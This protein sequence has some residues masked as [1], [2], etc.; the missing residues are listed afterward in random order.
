MRYDMTKASSVGSGHNKDV[1]MIR[2][3]Q[4][5]RNITKY[6]DTNLLDFEFWQGEIDKHLKQ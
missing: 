6:N 4:T 2:Y 5:K 3:M 1:L